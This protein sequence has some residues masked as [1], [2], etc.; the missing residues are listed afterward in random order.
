MNF[1]THKK[2]G[3]DT[4][5]LLT[6]LV[7]GL[8]SV[9][10]L[11]FKLSKKQACLPFSISSASVSAGKT[12]T[13]Y[14]GDPVVFVATG[15]AQDV[16]WDFGDHTPNLNGNNAKHIYT[17]DGHYTV[18]A[19]VNGE[20][21]ETIQLHVKALENQ[22]TKP[23]TETIAANPISGPDALTTNS[24]VTFTSTVK[25]GKYEWNILNSPIFV[26]QQTEVAS[27]NFPIA[28][29]L[30][31]EL[32]LDGDPAKVYRKQITVLPGK[33]LPVTTAPP[34]GGGGI[35]Q[36]PPPPVIVNMPPKKEE[37]VVSNPTTTTTPPVAEVKKDKLLIADAEFQ[38]KFQAVQR[39]DIDAS[40][41]NEFLCDGGQT[42][43]LV[44]ND[45]NKWE[46]VAGI[47]RFFNKNK[48]IK[49]IYDVKTER[50][51]KKC[52]TLI[53]LKYKTGGFLGL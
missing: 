35:S 10:I 36:K 39:G 6:F 16:A 29:N 27:Y 46:T 23:T 26:T 37:P 42:R 19:T 11:G 48:K 28:G 44:E 38:M 9:G 41:F 13:F 12:A 25:A 51:D 17:R 30:I 52:V 1:L 34:A 22:G 50:D 4:N 21:V 49:K 5:V 3:I 45:E 43:V 32:K 8:V 15:G 7:V 53:R 24:P 31:L 40:A 18:A 47:C 20:C 2:F 33:E 14:V